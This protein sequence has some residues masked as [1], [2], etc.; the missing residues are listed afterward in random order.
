NARCIRSLIGESPVRRA[1]ELR[2]V[3]GSMQRAAGGEFGGVGAPGELY[4]P[5]RACQGRRG[6]ARGAAGGETRP[7]APRCARAITGIRSLVPLAQRRRTWAVGSA[8]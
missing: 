5:G 3:S 4:R 8:A 1:A 6:A 2:G 7:A